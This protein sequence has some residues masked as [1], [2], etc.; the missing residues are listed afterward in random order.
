MIHIRPETS[1]EVSIHIVKHNA[2]HSDGS[3]GSVVRN[4]E[5]REFPRRP[6]YPWRAKMAI[7]RCALPQSMASMLTGNAASYTSPAPTLFSICNKS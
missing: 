5:P 2:A 6:S 4:H 1:S 3:E 7:G